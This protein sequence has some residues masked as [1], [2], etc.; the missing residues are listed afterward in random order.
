M[1]PYGSSFLKFICL[2]FCTIFPEQFKTRL[3]IMILYHILSYLD[4]RC[5]SIAVCFPL[6]IP[7]SNSSRT[8]R[9]LGSTVI[10]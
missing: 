2:Y 10:P 7:L 1:F 6:S 4:Y 3:I 5:I 9:N 8:S